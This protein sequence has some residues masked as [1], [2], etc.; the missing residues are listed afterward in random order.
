MSEQLTR[1]ILEKIRAGRLDA[2]VG[3]E[4]LAC[5][6]TGV[7]AEA[8]RAEA[9]AVV[10][11]S[12]CFPDA[13][14][15][16]SF[17]QHLLD[18]RDM[19]REVE[20]LRWLTADHYRP[21]ADLPGSTNC[22]WQGM[23]PDVDRFDPL[24]FSISPKEARQMDPQQRLVLQ[25]SWRAVEDAGYTPA[26]LAAGSCGVF[27][28]VTHGDYDFRAEAAGVELS[29]Q[30]MTGNLISM[31]AGRVSY[32]L[33][34][35][36]PNL[37]ID[38]A[39]SSSLVAL[40]EAVSALRAGSCDAALAGGVS[41]FT[42]ARVFQTA[43]RGGM[44]SPTGRCR[45]FD[46]AADGFVP[47]EAVGMVLLKRL[48]DAE[49]DRDHIYGLIEAYGTN[50][51]GRSN[52]MTAPSPESQFQLIDRLYRD[53]GI[54]SRSISYVET[55]GTGTRLGDPIEISALTRAFRTQTADTGFCRIGSVKSNVGHAMGASGIVSFIKVLRC[56]QEQVLVG[57][58]HFETPNQQIDFATT[59]FEVCTGI[60]AWPAGR[61]PRRAAI[62]SFGL[63]GTNAHLVVREYQ[64]PAPSTAAGDPRRS[65]ELVLLSAQSPIALRD[66][67]TELRRWLD[68]HSDVRWDDLVFTLGDG[69]QAMDHRIAIVASSVAELRGELAALDDP[70]VLDAR[71]TQVQAGLLGGPESD[72]GYG[73][74]VAELAGSAQEQRDPL[75]RRLAE[76]VL[77]GHDPAPY[78]TTH[79]AGEPFPARLALPT[80]RFVRERCWIENPTERPGAVEPPV[81]R[82][83][84]SEPAAAAA[85][86]VEIPVTASYL[87]D[88]RFAGAPVV[89]G[90]RWLDL[91]DQL[92]DGHSGE[93]R[94]LDEVNWLNLVA[95]GERVEIRHRRHDR[96]S[97]IEVT[98]L[99]GK[100][101]AT[102]TRPAPDTAAANRLSQGL[103]TRLLDSETVAQ[104]IDPARLYEHFEATGMSY[105]PSFQ[106]ITAI[107][108]HDSHVVAHLEIPQVAD[109]EPGSALLP[110][111]LDAVLQSVAA[112]KFVTSD[113]LAGWYLPH[114]IGR[115]SYRAG[116]DALASAVIRRSTAPADDGLQA[117]E[118]EAFDALG[119][120]ILRIEDYRIVQVQ[121]QTQATTAVAGADAPV[122]LVPG[123]VSGTAAVSDQ[124]APSARHIGWPIE[125]DAALRQVAD[126]AGQGSVELVIELPQP[127]VGAA[128]AE[129]QEQILRPV[130]EFVQA[131][132]SQPQYTSVRLLLVVPASW[133]S[134]DPTHHA[135][136]GFARSVRHEEPWLT[137]TTLYCGDDT[138]P[139]A[140]AAIVETEL[141]A[142]DG[143]LSVAY[144]PQRQVRTLLP[145]ELAPIDRLPAVIA[146]D[147]VILIAGGLGG[148]GTLL[149]GDLLRRGSPT[150]VL[151]GRGA[152]D[153]ARLDA[154][155]AHADRAGAVHYVRCDVVDPQ[156]C[157]RLVAQVLAEHGR[158]DGVVFCS[159][160]LRD[161]YLKFKP[162][163]QAREVLQVK[164][165]GLV[166]LD[167]ATAG[168]PLAFFV[169][170]SSIGSLQGNVGQTDYAMANAYLDAYLQDRAARVAAGQAAGRSFAINWPFWTDGGMRP[171]DASLA[172]MHDSF[173][174]SGLTTK[175][176]LGSLYALLDS[177]HPQCAVLPGDPQRLRTRF[178]ELATW[179]SAA[180]TVASEVPPQ[181]GDAPDW[182]EHE[183]RRLLREIIAQGLEIDP[184]RIDEDRAFEHYGLDSVLV[185]TINAL[186]AERFPGLSK[187]LLY[188]YQ[189]LA[190]LTD[191]FLAHKSAELRALIGRP[192]A[193]MAAAPAV[194]AAP[195][196]S[197]AEL[198]QPIETAAP[199][200]QATA[201]QPGEPRP[202]ADEIAIVGVSGRFPQA[203]SIDEFW[204]N[205]AAG[206]DS[207]VEI[208]TDRWDLTQG[209]HD[210]S[211]ASRGSYASRWG[212]FVE[213][214]RDFDPLM[215]GMSPR[216]AENTDPQ[217][218]V[219]LQTCWEALADAGYG[220]E[221]VRGSSTGVFVGVMYNHYQLYGAQASA[222]GVPLALNSNSA[223]IANRVS[224]TF[225]LAGPSLAVDSMCSSSLS[226]IHLACQAIRA[227]DCQMALAGGVNATLH[228]NKYQLLGGG[229]FLSTDGRCRSYGE[230]GDGYVPGEGV[231]CVLL[232]PLARARADG[233]HVYAI[234]K[235]SAVNHGGKT[236]GYTVPNPIAQ[237]AVISRA[238]E[239]AQLGFDDLSYIEG[240]GTG[241]SLGD[242]I[243]I[244]GLLRAL[245][246]QH[247]GGR[248]ALGSVK[249]N[250]GHLESAAG[251]ASLIKVLLMM[252]HRSLVPSLHSERLNPNIDFAAGPFEV[253]QRF[254]PWEPGAGRTLRRALITGFGAGGSNG[255]LVVEEMPAET[256]RIDPGSLGG[257]IF[258]VSAR[259][260][261][262]LEGYV[263]ELRDYLTAQAAE[264]SAAEQR[265][266]REAAL[267]LGLQRTLMV[268]R[269]HNQ[270]RLLIA[271][272]DLAELI[273]TLTRI[274]EQGPATDDAGWRFHKTSAQAP[275]AVADDDYRQALRAGDLGLLGER[276]LAGQTVDWEQLPAG[277]AAAGR[278][279]GVP[280]P[281]PDLQPYWYDTHLERPQRPQ[282]AT[283]PAARGTPG[284][285]PSA[286]Q[287]A[288]SLRVKMGEVAAGGLRPSVR[289]EMD[290]FGVAVVTMDQPEHNNSFTPDLIEGLMAAFWQIWNDQRVKAVVLTG[291]DRV[292][293]MGGTK[294]QLIAISNQEISFTD[295]PFLYAGLLLTEVPVVTAVRGHASGGG[296]LLGLFGDLVVLSADGVYSCPFTKYGFTPGMGATYILERRL[297]R[298]LALEMMLTARS[299]TGAELAARGAGV[300]VHD[301]DT[302]L[303]EA[304]ALARTIASHPRDTSTELKAHM[305]GTSLD[306]LLAM[307]ELEDAMHERTFVADNVE[308]NIANFYINADRKARLPQTPLPSATT[309]PPED[310]QLLLEE[311]LDLVEQGSLTPEQALLLDES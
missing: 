135:L 212:G 91:M 129:R 65:S 114:S 156:D 15:I 279:H 6:S 96:A 265:A 296:L 34:L 161:N 93:I 238:M 53:A 36:G 231:G 101:V 199:R 72:A 95:P 270:Y 120:P 167:R 80:Y 206:V 144:D 298:N 146:D 116:L 11:M 89:P 304:V 258:L 37:S 57:N 40:G 27:I 222:L 259:T 55:H 143:A 98:A 236:N 166:N 1:A 307:I 12:G 247:S 74:L 264:L 266:A 23:V 48:S 186:L 42:T 188:E 54:D 83:T 180:T 196:V 149:A 110:H 241:T 168:L 73:Q 35:T 124:Q 159:G 109:L 292:F 155:A 301:P 32:H 68:R 99:D 183:S 136:D 273:S 208:P 103:D 243:E 76:Y 51:D 14:D 105:G 8:S 197:R 134:A 287:L 38:T 108:I 77:A 286:Q 59:P 245:G 237:A 92:V 193:P 220:R 130:F 52:G 288:A 115:I 157:Q 276:W 58:L 170:Y 187:T 2:A 242:P 213:S 3:A 61:N 227:G 117:F 281:G 234:I 102:A 121:R 207:I 172:V 56:L 9:I 177:D 26:Q 22:K 280:W 111:A 257:H 122:F 240:H 18:G 152:P 297:G 198:R 215:F 64:E 79:P 205:L 254:G 252:R 184:D 86:Q 232:K 162:W 97:R 44:L 49:R 31:L 250:I 261:P 211:G 169:A 118:I 158:I 171:D 283:S 160:V 113:D 154:I 255:A 189:N 63:S 70:S 244:N 274:A 112:Y 4:L 182:F 262:A 126:A 229:N 282:V 21:E 104:R 218:R 128:V 131:L 203:E 235:G 278:L 119:A 260:L 300:K 269:D 84:V 201:S 47:S 221:A 200:S 123:F 289:L 150:L 142:T 71:L 43:G 132:V 305:L 30:S 284:S 294:E 67:I 267:L 100:P 45:A 181:D 295:A 226:S 178:V 268:G 107:D 185:V 41:V 85:V 125:V 10:G 306:E 190:D 225:D 290:E 256:R 230:G 253:V 224:Y 173:G 311:L 202:P 219:F 246:E 271:A 75:V 195:S 106:G 163:Q 216:D 164:S 175:A 28:G 81:G 24:F 33:N 210:P 153:Q 194:A 165:D 60:S 251:I 310:D 309:E 50:H 90:A 308:E 133:Q 291:S 204:S 17:W 148:L 277:F 192:A 29:A 78:V 179:A 151:A 5:S 69:R 174:L 62:S 141:R 217:E 228:E 16:D 46:E 19:V 249:S 272:D 302:V 13:P 66:N 25:E 138:S 88:H 209:H 145:A 248:C 233:D 176:G 127:A 299:Y 139:A 263:G 20:P 303:T 223:S 140:R 94:V 275:A 239:R 214:M 147:A 82:S 293:S 7:P 87:A 39:C 137:I 191:Y 285:A